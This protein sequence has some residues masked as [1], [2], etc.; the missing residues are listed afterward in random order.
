MAK[1]NESLK[2]KQDVDAWF[3]ETGFK[4]VI[5]MGGNHDLLPFHRDKISTY[6]N[7]AILLENTVTEF[8]NL[9]IYDSREEPSVDKYNYFNCTELCEDDWLDIL[10]TMDVLIFH[11][12]PY[13]ILDHVKKN[14]NSSMGQRGFLELLNLLVEE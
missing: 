1:Q 13:G 9:K 2:Q 8:E 3:G 7:N 6:F 4:Q 5:V 14:L 10:L 12:P 11:Y